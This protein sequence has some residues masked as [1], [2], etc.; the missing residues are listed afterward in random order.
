MSRTSNAP[1]ENGDLCALWP[2]DWIPAY[3]PYHPTSGSRGLAAA[4]CT[5]RQIIAEE[6]NAPQVMGW[7]AI[8]AEGGPEV[9]LWRLIGQV[10]R[11][12]GRSW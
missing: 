5:W 7:H 2:Y 3:Q 11:H 1:G 10:P 6:C 12:R 8:Y 9:I 4:S